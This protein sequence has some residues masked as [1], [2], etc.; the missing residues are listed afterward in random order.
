MG[1]TLDMLLQIVTGK[2]VVVFRQGEWAELEYDQGYDLDEVEHVLD[3]QVKELYGEA[4]VDFSYGADS[5]VVVY[6]E[7]EEY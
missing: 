1:I 7:K 5:Y 3:K 4:E 2:V 6:L